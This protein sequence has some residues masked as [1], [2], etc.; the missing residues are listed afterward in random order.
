MSTIGKLVVLNE[1]ATSVSVLGKEFA[2][3]DGMVEFAEGDEAHMQVLERMGVARHP[4]HH[5]AVLK[6]EAEA[7]AAAEAARVD[8]AA[9]EMMKDKSFLQRVEARAAELLAA[10]KGRKGR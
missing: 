3:K 4:E 2:V 10:E 6:A 5:A 9:R 1:H 7:A 8:A